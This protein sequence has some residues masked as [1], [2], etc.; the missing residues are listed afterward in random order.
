M[1][2]KLVLS[3]MVAMLAIA[4]GISACAVQA[5]PASIETQTVPVVESAPADSAAVVSESSTLSVE[6][7]AGLLYMYEEEKLARDA[8]NALFTQWGQPIFQSI[9]T[10]EQRHMDSVYALLVRYGIAVPASAAGVFNDPTLQ[11]LYNGLMSTGSQS[12]ADALKVGATIEEVDIADLQ[13]RLAATANADIQWVYNNLMNGSYN[14]L[15]N[16]VRVL[17][18][19]TGETYQPQ[20]LVADLY[21]TIVTSNNG[22]GYGNSATAADGGRGFRGGK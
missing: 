16:Y 20:Y 18:R 8:Y 2:K 10:S 12:L 14:H 3:S 15:R 17:G 1:F 13:S 5:A 21:Q 7:T 6:E 19:L 22:N 4:M 11:S 9:A